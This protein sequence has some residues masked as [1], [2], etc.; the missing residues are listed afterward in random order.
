MMGCSH[1]FLGNCHYLH[2]VFISISFRLH[3]RESLVIWPSIVPCVIHRQLL[4]EGTLWMD[5][6]ELETTNIN[7]L[8]ADVV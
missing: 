6:V 3:L 2:Y 7:V 4:L 5:G 8:Y 1:I